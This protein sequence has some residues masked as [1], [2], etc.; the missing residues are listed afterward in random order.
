[1]EVGS[2]LG[3]VALGSDRGWVGL[4]WVGLGLIGLELVMGWAWAGLGAGLVS[5]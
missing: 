1:M 5:A 2:G 3:W 4:D